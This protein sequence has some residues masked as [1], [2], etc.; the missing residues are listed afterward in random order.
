MEEILTAKIA[1][2]KKSF[3]LSFLYIKGLDLKMDLISAEG[4]KNAGVNVLKIEKT[5]ELWISMKDVGVGLGVKSISD[6]VLKEI[7]GICEKKLTKEE[8]T[9]YK[10]TEREFYEKFYKSS[11][12]ELNK[13][14]NKK[15]FVKNTIMTN[16]IN[17]CRG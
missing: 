12:D 3:F 6:L 10:M 13:N 4:Y 15:V 5:D 14:S 7:H 17:H 1:N 8:T 16:I 11:E 9:C 2:I